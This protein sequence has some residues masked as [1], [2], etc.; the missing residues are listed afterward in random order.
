[1]R[2]AARRRDPTLLAHAHRG[3]VDKGD[4][5]V[6]VTV[7][8]GVHGVQ[9]RLPLRLAPLRIVSAHRFAK[10]AARDGLVS[11]HV[12]LKELALREL[13][14]GRSERAV[15]AHK[16]AVRAQHAVGLRFRALASR[17]ALVEVLRGGAFPAD[18]LPYIGE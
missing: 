17:A 4:A 6:A 5:P 1:M 12:E 10:V 14:L 16:A 9:L 8:R 7:D 2:Y 11:V 18:H 3:E 13:H 15:R